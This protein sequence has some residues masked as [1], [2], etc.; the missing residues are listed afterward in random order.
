MYENNI[1]IAPSVQRLCHEPDDRG[2]IPGRGKNISFR[3]R[4][5]TDSGAHAASYSMGSGSKPT[6]AWSWPYIYF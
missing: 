4:V 5:Q 1:Y 6:E 2:Y 3:N